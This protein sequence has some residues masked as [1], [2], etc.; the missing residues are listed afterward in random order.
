MRGSFT[1]PYLVPA[2]TSYLPI[3]TEGQLLVMSKVRTEAAF[4]DTPVARAYE[5]WAWEGVPPYPVQPAC[6]KVRASHAHMRQ[7]AI[8]HQSPHPPPRTQASDGLHDCTIT[9]AKAGALRVDMIN[10]TMPE[11]TAERAVAR[12]LLQGTFG[13]T[14]KSLA[15]FATAHG[16]ADSKGVSDWIDAQAAIAPTFHR[17]Y[18]RARSS[19]RLDASL[20]NGDPYTPCDINTRFRSYSFTYKDQGK[21]LTAA[22]IAG[23]FALSLDGKLHTEV[24]S[25]VAD[26][27]A[28]YVICRVYEGEG[29]P[30]G[31]PALDVRL[32]SP[33]HT[34][35]HTH[36][37]R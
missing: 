10:A 32:F 13:P 19:P 27:V 21:T 37:S 24:A 29:F 20:L 5:R 22:A 12:L 25:F 35:V 14:T 2:G 18:M 4:E 30:V 26:P 34:H 23:G 15:D 1:F 9:S 28:S 11:P 8:I 36:R 6:T 33:P 7:A 17:A 31:C 3:A 16:A